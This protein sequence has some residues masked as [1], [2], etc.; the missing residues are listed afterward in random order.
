MFG[1]FPL[2]SD[3]A[4][5]VTPPSL[6]G[7]VVALHSPTLTL[8]AV[9]PKVPLAKVRKPARDPRFDQLP[10]GWGYSDCNITLINKI[11]APFH[12]QLITGFHLSQSSFS[13]LDR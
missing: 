7:A 3:Q 10:Q 6:G 12:Q 2:P 11:G 1:E 4:P 13:C 9:A 5:A 8:E